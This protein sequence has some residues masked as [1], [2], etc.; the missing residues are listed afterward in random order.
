MKVQVSWMLLN[1]DTT[2]TTTTTAQTLLGSALLSR[3]ELE[4]AQ[5]CGC[6]SVW[7]WLLLLRMRV[8]CSDCK[9]PGNFYVNLQ[10]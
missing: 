2:M 7:R 9:Y 5:L 4:V 1:F 8:L 3:V 6:A 10:L